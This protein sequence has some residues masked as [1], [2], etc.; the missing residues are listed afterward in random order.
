MG[1]SADFCKGARMGAV[2]LLLLVPESQAIPVPVEDLDPIAASTPEDEKMPRQRI[3]RQGGL[4]Q[5]GERV[6]AF[7][8][9]GRA[10]T[11]EDPHGR[12]PAQHRRPSST[13]RMS[14][15]V[16]GS[17]PAGTRTIGPSFNRISI[18]GAGWGGAR[19]ASTMRTGRK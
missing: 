2:S 8:H 5:V 7:S 1:V 15:S 12:G 6:E 17:N 14:P 11:E 16:R 10:G 9:V 3:E 4:D 18:G 13:A 19:S